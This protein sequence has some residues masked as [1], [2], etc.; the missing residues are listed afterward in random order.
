MIAFQGLDT[1]DGSNPCV[2]NAPLP[3]LSSCAIKCVDR[4]TSIIPSS[5]HQ[6]RF[7]PNVLVTVRSVLSQVLG[8]YGLIQKSSWKIKKT[9]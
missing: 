4:L 8:V 5:D 9:I 3:Y 7:N 2:E 1:V 6:G